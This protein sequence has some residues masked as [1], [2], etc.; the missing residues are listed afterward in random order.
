[1]KAQSQGMRRSL[2]HL[3]NGAPAYW[4]HTNKEV[5]ENVKHINAKGSNKKKNGKEA[6]DMRQCEKILTLI[7]DFRF[8][9]YMTENEF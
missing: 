1:M 2:G 3:L 5:G 4:G 6:V 7:F 8:W 9:L